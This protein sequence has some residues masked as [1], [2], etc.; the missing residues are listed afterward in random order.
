MGY[1]T[2]TAECVHCH[3]PFTFNPMR[4][5]SVVVNG[6]REPLCEP[7]V[8]WANAER[9]RRGLPLFTVHADAYEPCDEQA[10]VWPE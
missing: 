5:P 1:I 4:V 10:M 8:T 9:E 3:Q 2:A 7:C 6:L